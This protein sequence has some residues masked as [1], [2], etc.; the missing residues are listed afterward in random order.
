MI[1]TVYDDTEG[2]YNFNDGTTVKLHTISF[3]WIYYPS[4]A[5]RFLTTKGGYAKRTMQNIVLLF[6]CY[7]FVSICVEQ[8]WRKYDTGVRKVRIIFSVFTSSV[9]IGAE[10]VGLLSVKDRGMIGIIPLEDGGQKMTHGHEVVPR[11]VKLVFLQRKC[12]QN[13]YTWNS[14]RWSGRE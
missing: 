4:N 2:F 5:F 8:G 9:S 1:F 11:K 10:V 13:R 14:G 7:F 12:E 6:Y 3:E